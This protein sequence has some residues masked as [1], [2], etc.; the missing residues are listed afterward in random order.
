MLHCLRTW[1]ANSSEGGDALHM[2]MRCLRI[3][4]AAGRKG[5]I[6]MSLVFSMSFHCSCT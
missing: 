4:R 1:C 5:V 3:F 2:S 6:A